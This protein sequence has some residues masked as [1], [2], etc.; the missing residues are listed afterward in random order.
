MATIRRGS[1]KPGDIVREFG[2][3]SL[4]HDAAGVKIPPNVDLIHVSKLVWFNLS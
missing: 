4:Q 1:E 3:D 2:D